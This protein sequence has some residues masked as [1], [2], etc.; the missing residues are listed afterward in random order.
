MGTRNIL[1]ALAKTLK[2]INKQLYTHNHKRHT[3]YLQ[4]SIQLFHLLI[5]TCG[6]LLKNLAVAIRVGTI[7]SEAIPTLKRNDNSVPNL[8]NKKIQVKIRST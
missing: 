3:G 5:S 4:S 8:K 2:K 7:A 6:N 1:P